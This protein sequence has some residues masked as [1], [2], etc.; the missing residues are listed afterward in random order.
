MS[1]SGR[2][3]FLCAALLAGSFAVR[4]QD[5]GWITGSV[6]DQSGAAIPRATVNL[7]LHGGSKP[8]ATTVTTEQGLFTLQTLR[9]VYYDLTVDA[10]GFQ[11]Y[12]VGNVKV[13]PSRPTDLPKITMMVATAAASV[14]VTAGLET[15]QTTSPELSTTVT[16]EQI[17][18]LPV[19]DRNPLEFISTQAGVSPGNANGYETDINGQRS[20]F[21]NVTLDGI[22]IQD[23]YIRTGGLD[24]TPNEPFL[25]QVQEFTVIS[26]NQG[27]ASSGGASQ[28][29]FTTPSGTNQFHGAA[30]WQNR[31]NDFAA[32]DFFDNQDGNPLPRLNLN[33]GGVEV[34]GPIKKDK[35]FFYGAYELFRERQQTEVDATVLTQTARQGIFSY[36][37]S[38]GQV[39][40]QNLLSITGLPMDPVMSS[41][42]AKVPGPSHINN[43]RVGDSQAGLLLNTAGY[44]F[45]ARNNQ[46]RDN[47]LG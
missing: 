2:R 24:Y 4:A 14:S 30:F 19:G 45:L 26:S 43:F 10:A 3:R 44:G 42:L 9:P 29:N 18:R 7:L 23:N 15:V 33:Q 20:S 34:G 6:T 32:N 28:V 40:Q 27:A 17:E 39:Q 37:D 41:L 13:D 31:N 38:A 35:L 11:Q 36:V 8:V 46:D 22:N 12:K 1:R 16:A 47:V 25:S 5:T 21:S